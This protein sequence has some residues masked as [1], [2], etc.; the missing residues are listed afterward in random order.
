MSALVPSP[1]GFHERRPS[2][3][4]RRAVT[5]ALRYAGKFPQRSQAHRGNEGAPNAGRERFIRFNGEH[6]RVL[7]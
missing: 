6:P 5:L 4:E 2:G 3:G 1:R 7:D